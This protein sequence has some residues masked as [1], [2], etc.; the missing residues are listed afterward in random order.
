MSVT[1]ILLLVTNLAIIFTNFG[2]IIVTGMD[3]RAVARLAALAI[4]MIS[5][6]KVVRIEHQLRMDEGLHHAEK[7]GKRDEEH[8]V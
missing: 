5:P 2:L 6:K 3:N 7:E 4:S 8:N 1:E